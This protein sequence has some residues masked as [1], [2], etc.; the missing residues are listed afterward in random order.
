MSKPVL[1]IDI[2]GVMGDPIPWWL[3]LYNYHHHT[4]H[5][6]FQVTDWDTRVCIGADLSP[7]FGNYDMVE[8]I[9]GAL[10]SVGILWFKYRIVYATAGQGSDWLRKYI[11]NPEIIRIQDKSLLRGFALIDD[12]P[13]NLDGFVG[14]RFLLSQPWNAN[15]GLNDTTWEEITK[16]LMKEKTQ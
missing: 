15:R 6:K 2:D 16:Y 7:Y 14:E 10:R 5:Y 13:M 4:N 1:F 9:K 11:S 12:N 3:E 8:P